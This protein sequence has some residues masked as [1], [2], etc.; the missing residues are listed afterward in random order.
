MVGVLFEYK[1][2]TREGVRGME[3]FGVCGEESGQRLEIQI[4]F[5]SLNEKVPM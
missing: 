4:L 1:G 3:A 2:E 5:A